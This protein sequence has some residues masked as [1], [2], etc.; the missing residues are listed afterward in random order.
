VINKL[1]YGL[2]NLPFV[3]LIAGTTTENVV[4]TAIRR[5]R[6]ERG[7]HERGTGLRLAFRRL[8]PPPPRAGDPEKLRRMYK[9]GSTCIWVGC[10]GVALMLMIGITLL[11]RG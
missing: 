4:M 7:Y 5:T 3:L 6:A 9:I 11:I 10:A 8:F 1:I 2:V